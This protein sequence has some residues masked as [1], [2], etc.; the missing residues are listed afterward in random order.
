VTHLTGNH[1]EL[2]VKGRKL[3]YTVHFTSYKAVA[4]RRRQ[5]WGWKWR[6]VSQVTVSDPE[7]TLFHRKSPNMAVE[8]RKF[9]YTVHF[10]SY[11]AVARRR[12]QSR[13]LR[14]AEVTRTWRHLTGSHL[15]VAVDGRK[16]AYTVHFTSYKA[17]AHRRRQ[18]RDKKWRYVNSGH[19][20]WLGSDVI[21]PEVT[22][23]CQWKAENLHIL[24]ISSSYKAVAR[25]RRQ[26]LVRKWRH[27]PSGDLKW[28][29]SDVISLEVTWKRLWKAKN[30][31]TL[32]ISLPTRLYLAGG[33]HVT[34]NVTWPQVP[35][36]D[37]Q[38]TSLDRKSP[39]SGGGRPKTHVY[40]TFHFLQGCS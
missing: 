39:G 26:S 10:T 32:Y 29:G 25:M 28:P 30:R 36:S 22:W 24:Y 34:G 37:P 40:C 15:E 13:D 21:W 19:R 16:L 9:A 38:V 35:G 31:S 20:R 5:S 3:A 1:L 23:K 17:V 12:R 14:R 18:S 27:V 4:R 7:V 11:T 6:H 8:V 2:P 33:N